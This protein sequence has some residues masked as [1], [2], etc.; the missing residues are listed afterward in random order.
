MP[1]IQGPSSILP[2][3][4]PRE[5]GPGQRNALD[6]QDFMKLFTAQLRAQNPS[7]PLDT[8]AMMQQMSQL[9]S[10]SATEA[11]EKSVKSLNENL[12]KSQIMGATQAIGKT[13]QIPSKVS[14]LVKGEGLNGSAIVPQPASAVTITIKDD[15]NNVVKTIEKPGSGAGVVDFEWDGKDDSGKELEPK[16]YHISATATIAGNPVEIPTAGNFKVKSVALNKTTG[17]II[18]NVD[19]L[20]GVEMS[21][22]VKILNKENNPW[23]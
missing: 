11:L 3:K 18:F 14:P 7:K 8:A 10:L 23:A 15:N 2:T 6:Q 5:R 4:V 19:G 21:H 22:I 1:N 13:V 17:E 20:G 16:F 12:N 9:A